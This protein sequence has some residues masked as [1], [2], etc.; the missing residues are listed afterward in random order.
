MKDLPISLEER[1][2]VLSEIWETLKLRE[3]KFSKKTGLKKLS[4]TVYADDTLVYKLDPHSTEAEAL[5]RVKDLRNVQKFIA[6]EHNVLVSE[7][8]REEH[9]MPKSKIERVHLENLLQLLVELRNR[10]V[11][12]RDCHELNMFYSKKNGFT[13]IDLGCDLTYNSKPEILTYDLARMFSAKFDEVA[14]NSTVLSNYAKI[15]DAFYDVNSEVSSETLKKY[16]IDETLLDSDMK[17][18]NPKSK[19]FKQMQKALIKYGF[20]FKELYCNTQNGMIYLQK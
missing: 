20:E 18:I 13:L 2:L 14:V 10:D 16:L 17:K 1:L 12:F 8:I 7:R 15:I 3:Q 19:Q 11:E 4:S 6:Y 5:Q 9:Y